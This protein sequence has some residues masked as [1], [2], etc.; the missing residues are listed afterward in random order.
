MRSQWLTR[1]KTPRRPDLAANG[2]LNRIQKTPSDLEL[3]STC[4]SLAKDTMCRA[5]ILPVINNVEFTHATLQ[6]CCCAPAFR[7]QWNLNTSRQLGT[8]RSE[9]CS[10]WDKVVPNELSILDLPVVT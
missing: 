2:R 10:T 4:P 7:D 5:W 1:G 9:S 3:C 6:Q 8:I